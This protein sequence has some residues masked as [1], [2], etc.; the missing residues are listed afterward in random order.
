MFVR[1]LRAKKDTV[2]WKMRV[3]TFLIIERGIRAC[4]RA[5]AHVVRTN[6]FA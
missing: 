4:N 6:Q 5:H 1:A 2:A 3:L